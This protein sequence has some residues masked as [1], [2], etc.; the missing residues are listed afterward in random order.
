MTNPLE[1]VDTISW[2]R[3]NAVPLWTIRYLELRGLLEHH[4][5]NPNLVRI[6]P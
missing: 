5:E 4:P 2:L 1:L 3:V 6:K